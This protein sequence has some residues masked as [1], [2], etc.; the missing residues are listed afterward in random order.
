MKIKE[1]IMYIIAYFLAVEGLSWL[2]G[3][4]F[5]NFD[6]IPILIWRGYFFKGIV[7]FI[8]MLLVYV[9]A[10]CAL[11]AGEKEGKTALVIIMLIL[12]VSIGSDMYDYYNEDSIVDN[13]SMVI[14]VLMNSWDDLVKIFTIG[15]ALKIDDGTF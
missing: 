1:I 6:M 5:E 8:I 10:A 7:L 3:K 2:C 9:I 12:L 14:A 13:I 11:S 15:I 4:V